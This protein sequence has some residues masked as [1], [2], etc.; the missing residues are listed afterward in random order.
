MVRDFCNMAHQMS[1]EPKDLRNDS[2]TQII[3][4]QIIEFPLIDIHELLLQSTDDTIYYHDQSSPIS[5]QTSIPG[6]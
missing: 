4:R 1:P 2:A 3:Q 6:P 5:I